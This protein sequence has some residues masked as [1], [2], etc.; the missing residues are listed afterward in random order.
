MEWPMKVKRALLSRRLRETA[1]PMRAS[2]ISTNVG[3]SLSHARQIERNHRA[4]LAPRG[5]HLASVHLRPAGHHRP[6]R[7]APTTFDHP[8][9][10]PFARATYRTLIPLTAG[11]RASGCSRPWRSDSYWS[12]GSRDPC[13]ETQSKG[14]IVHLSSPELDWSD[15]GQRTGSSC[16]LP[17]FPVRVPHAWLSRRHGTGQSLDIC[18]ALQEAQSASVRARRARWHVGAGHSCGELIASRIVARSLSSD[19]G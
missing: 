17:P 18:L 7:R 16:A 12:I 6:P 11:Y 5:N 4:P 2:C 13:D 19:T 3:L 9:E 10:M 8:S 15:A 1:S 14:G